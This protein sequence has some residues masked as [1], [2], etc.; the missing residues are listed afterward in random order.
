MTMG[1]RIT[2]QRKRLGLSQES[3]GE[4]LEVSRQAVT[5]WEADGTVPEIDKLIAMSKLFGVS[6]GWLLGVEEQSSNKQ[7]S[8]SEKQ[9]KII[10]GLV[11]KYQT[12]PQ[13]EKKQS[14]VAAA[15]CVISSL[16]AVILAWV[17]ISK[18]NTTNNNYD[19]QFNNLFYSYSDLQ[20]QLGEVSGQLNELVQ[21]EKLLTDYSF[22]AWAKNDLSGA[23]ISF[24]GTPR[25]W[26]TGDTAYLSVRFD[27]REVERAACAWDG[28]G[29]TARLELPPRDGY[30]YYYILSHADGS[31]EQQHLTGVYHYAVFVAEGLSLSGYAEVVC[32]Y[33]DGT[34]ILYHTF[35]DVSVPP[36]MQQDDSVTWTE[37][38]AVLY[39][40]GTELLRQDLLLGV[41]DNDQTYS[42]GA[43]LNSLLFWNIGEV[44][45]EDG[46]CVTARVM[47]KT[48]TG[49]AIDQQVYSCIRNGDSCTEEITSQLYI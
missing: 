41:D 30:S 11:E 25:Q 48:D 34:L 9:L 8:L 18:V 35:M 24:V 13:P 49:I 28:S 47:A 26:Q 14:R 10:E 27:D 40:N 44:V 19:T 29:S 36:L 37:A 6:V 12:P 4:K 23:E 31:Q 17:A 42:G 22:S 46:D 15:L 39:K 16:L 33:T 21:G 38:T 20:N 45:M 32:H 2:E 7:E 43:Y 1:Q 3:L 5:K